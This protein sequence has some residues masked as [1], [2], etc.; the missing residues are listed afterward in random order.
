MYEFEASKKCQ[1]AL[2]VQ[3]MFGY[4]IYN[5]LNELKYIY[6]I[7]IKLFASCKGGAL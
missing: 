6:I 7:I 1:V 4:D 3:Y 2:V 5:V